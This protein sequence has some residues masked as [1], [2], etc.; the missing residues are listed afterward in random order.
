M[1]RKIKV[2]IYTRKKKGQKKIRGNK[3][4]NINNKYR[5]IGNKQTSKQEGLLFDKAFK[6]KNWATQHS[7]RNMA[8]VYQNKKKKKMTRKEKQTDKV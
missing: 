5:K 1:T 6:N 3:K 7:R 2:E 8:S 4:K